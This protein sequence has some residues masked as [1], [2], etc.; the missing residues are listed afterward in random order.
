M[1]HSPAQSGS[2]AV[3]ILSKEKKDGLTLLDRCAKYDNG[4]GVA[5]EEKFVVFTLTTRT[6]FWLDL[7]NGPG[8]T[9]QLVAAAAALAENIPIYSSSEAQSHVS[10]TSLPSSQSNDI[11]PVDRMPW[12]FLNASMSRSHSI[13]GRGDAVETLLNTLR[14]PWCVLELCCSN[15]HSVKLL[16]EFAKTAYQLDPEGYEVATMLL[17]YELSHRATTE[18]IP[19]FPVSTNQPILTEQALLDFCKAIFILSRCSY[20]GFWLRVISICAIKLR[21]SFSALGLFLANSSEYPA[22]LRDTRFGQYVK[23]RAHHPV[24]VTSV[25]TSIDQESVSSVDNLGAIIETSRLRSGPD[26]EPRAFLV[27]VYLQIIENLPIS[28]GK[29]KKIG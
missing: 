11:D 25:A 9:P 29:E 21:T 20:S 23:H 28:T 27:C 12:F 15:K 1:L 3:Q 24:S 8:Y 5:R 13:L 7:A 6:Q 2:S 26:L 14:R 17:S 18:G 19:V 16:L 22:S 10:V 4:G